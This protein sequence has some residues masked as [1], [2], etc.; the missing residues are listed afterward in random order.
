[1]PVRNRQTLAGSDSGSATRFGSTTAFGFINQYKKDTQD[2]VNL[3]DN[4]AFNAT[5]V[6]I[7]GGRINGT[8]PGSP[9]MIMANFLAD[10]YRTSG[11]NGFGHLALSDKG[12][13]A[14]ATSVAARTSPSRPYVDVPVDIL[15]LGEVTDLIR[16]TGK[17]IL[18]F[19]G[20]QN[21]RYQ[22][23][24]AP[25]VDDI[26]KLCSFQEQV[27][28]RILELD[29]L[30]SAR[31]LRRTIK[32]GKVDSL[33]I[34]SSGSRVVNSTKSL[35]YTVPY[36]VRTSL[37]VGGHA[38]WIPS[39]SLSHLSPDRKRML[40]LRSVLGLTL[41]FKTLWEI[42][43]WSWLIDWGSSLGNYLAANRNIVPATLASV[44]VTRHTRTSHSYSGKPSPDTTSWAIPLA[45][46]EITVESKVRTP[47]S[48]APVAHFPFLKG[49]QLGILASLYVTR[50]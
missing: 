46:A 33:N 19:L 12:N 30:T 47:A 49:N 42:I 2:F 36:E 22:F 4:L 3:G 35:Q 10:Y 15:Q 8:G 32:L 25:L 16:K 50:R 41:D 7:I 1:M 17:G 44:S 20:T 40:A 21:L 28:R 31:G 26:Y 6:D 23:A 27:A 34:S 14:Y 39:V 37:E 43:P 11:V 13:V 29:R 45:P 48:I 5:T 9:P 24:I 18:A 38:R